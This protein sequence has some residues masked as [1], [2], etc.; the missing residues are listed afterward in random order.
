MVNK[1]SIYGEQI[2]T[3]KCLNYDLLFTIFLFMSIRKAQR[4]IHACARH[5]CGRFSP[6][7]LLFTPTRV[8]LEPGT[9]AALVFRTGDV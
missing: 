7:F 5:P 4:R 2:F 1:Y 9:S 3:T 8:S 6:R